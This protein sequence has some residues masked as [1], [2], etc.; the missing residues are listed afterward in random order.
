[1]PSSPLAT[2]RLLVLF[3]LGAVLLSALL[4]ALLRSGSPRAGAGPAPVREPAPAPLGGL[5][6][7]LPIQAGATPDE[8]RPAEVPALPAPSGGDGAAAGFDPALLHGRVRARRG[9]VL[10]DARVL[11]FPGESQL[12]EARR[13]LAEQTTD[14]EGCFR[15]PGREPHERYLVL[16][17]HPDFLPRL[18]RLVPGHAEELELEPALTIE[19]HVLAVESGAPLA[20]VELALEREHWSEGPAEFV[21]A[22][23]GADGAWQLPWAEPGIQE[24]LVLRAGFL[25]ER[26]E[27]Q[28]SA[29]EHTGYE[30]LL[31]G[32]ILAVIEV[33]S[34]ESGATLSD[35]EILVN[36][37]RLRTG[38]DGRLALALPPGGFPDEGY[39]LSLGAEGCCTT[40]GRLSLDEIV[41]PVRVPLARGT[42]VAGRVLDGSG[43]PVEG[44]LLRVQG[45]GRGATPG[46]PRDFWLSAPRQPVRSGADGRFELFGQ[47][48][49]E[50]NAHVRATHPDHPPAQSEPFSLAP[51]GGRS[52]VEIVFARGGTIAGTVTLDGEPASLRVSWSGPQGGGSTRANDRGQ[53]RLRGVASGEVRV[54]ARLDDEDEEEPREEDQLLWIEEDA[55]L[56]CDLALRSNRTVIAGSVRDSQGAPLSGVELWAYAGED[57]DEVDFEASAESEEDGSFELLVPDQAGL[58]FQVQAVSG[59]RQAWVEDVLPGA[60][61]VELVLPALGR[62]PLRVTDLLTREP[63]SGFLLYWRSGELGGFERLYQDG[64]RF[65]GGPDGVFVAELPAGTLDLAISARA[66]GYWPARIEGVELR[67]GEEART[68]AVELERGVALELSFTAAPEEAGALLAELRRSRLAL[69]TEEDLRDREREGAYFQQE[70]RNAQAVRIDREGRG[71]VKAL[72]PGRYRLF[73][74]PRGL[75]FHPREIEVPH[76]ERHEATV[77]V[78]RNQRPREGGRDGSPDGE[79]R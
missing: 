33:H 42:T 1:M 49:R 34:F 20:G 19:G 67:A 37:Q 46:M 58:R 3:L 77:R 22:L 63:V 23:S 12:R 39:R 62:L 69:A 60:R 71:R 5:A 56:T 43:A 57:D 25:P 26:R 66:Q 16:V 54:G 64:N 44:A 35:T 13:P 2:Q 32:E 52:A 21:R 79:R 51:Q 36:E 10:P 47:P 50:G 73:N 59:P 72:R 14:S 29:E 24:I 38:P 78:E 18:E 6:S 55:Q 40:Q 70:V 65:S 68:L 53:Y 9:P 48:P 11:L 41:S 7:A 15:F 61:G 74:G 4:L 8:R 31:G 75:V 30:I 76:V 45:G 17:Q 28:V 27:F